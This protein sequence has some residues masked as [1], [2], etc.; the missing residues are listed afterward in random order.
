MTHKTKFDRR[1]RGGDKPG[2]TGLTKLL[3][4]IMLFI[5]NIKSL[6]YNKVNVPLVY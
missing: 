2:Q 1:G 6:V 5:G 3:L 4:N